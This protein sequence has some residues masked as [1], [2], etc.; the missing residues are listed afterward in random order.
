MKGWLRA[1]KLFLLQQ[2]GSA[3]SAKDGR[4]GGELFCVLLKQAFLQNENKSQPKVT[5]KDG[6]PLQGPQM[7]FSAMICSFIMSLQT[8]VLCGSASSLPS[9]DDLKPGPTI[10][11]DQWG[12]EKTTLKA[13]IFLSSLPQP[14]ASSPRFV[15]LLDVKLMILTPRCVM[16]S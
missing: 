16:L 14:P 8:K 11:G 10:I 4:S 12:H 5:R 7:P 9:G 6:H 13:A 1:A 2:R 15:L 3:V